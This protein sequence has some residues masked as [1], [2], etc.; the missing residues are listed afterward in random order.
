MTLTE[1]DRVRKFTVRRCVFVLIV[2]SLPFFLFVVSVISDSSFFYERFSGNIVFEVLNWYSLVFAFLWG[3]FAVLFVLGFIYCFLLQAKFA[4]QYKDFIIADTL[5]G[6]FDRFEY[7]SHGIAEGLPQSI[8][9]GVGVVRLNSSYL[10]ND[11]F[12]ADYDG[13]HFQQADVRVDSFDKD[14]RRGVPIFFGRWMIFDFDKDFAT[15]VHVVQKGYYNNYA[16]RPVDCDESYKRVLT[17][18][19]VFDSCFD[20][21]T[22]A[23]S[24]APCVLIPVMMDRMR[25][26]LSA[27]FMVFS[28]FNKV[29]FCFVGHELH[30]GIHNKMNSFEPSVRGKFDFDSIRNH[31]SD[32]VKVSTDLMD[33]LALHS[34]SF[35]S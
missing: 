33:I 21:F 35:E 32:D 22:Q 15:N 26:V 16:V 6:A 7:K 28:E 10:S 20:V 17:G 31:V 3:L 12:E 19:D 4:R 25:Q 2:V 1:L 5:N 8:P 34:V 30:V 27:P 11:Y 29:F 14:F 23:P 24:L 18:D 9:A 13:V